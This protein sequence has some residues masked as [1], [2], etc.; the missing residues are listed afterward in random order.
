MCST[1]EEKDNDDD[2]DDGRPLVESRDG[3]P[4]DPDTSSP[5]CVCGRRGRRLGTS[6][7]SILEFARLGTVAS[8]QTLAFASACLTVLPAG[9]GQARVRPTLS[10]LSV[11]AAVLAARHLLLRG[12]YLQW[13][14]I[15][16]KSSQFDLIFSLPVGSN[17]R[18]K[19]KFIFWAR[20]CGL[21]RWEE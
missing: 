10:I 13:Q 19:T 21:S 18:I 3:R 16:N 17:S 15:G 4:L 7:L 2:D 6:V 11:F 8:T 9:G 14:I 5:V 1:F 20:L 12:H